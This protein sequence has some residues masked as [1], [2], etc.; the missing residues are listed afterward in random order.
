MIIDEK[1]FAIHEK[2]QELI[3]ELMKRNQ[4]IMASVLD[5]IG[6]EHYIEAGDTH[7]FLDLQCIRDRLVSLYHL[8]NAEF[9]FGRAE[10]QMVN[11][12]SSDKDFEWIKPVME[13]RIKFVEE[14][15]LDTL[16]KLFKEARAFKFK[17]YRAREFQGFLC[18]ALET[19]IKG[20]KVNYRL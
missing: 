15:L 14:E 8:I 6:N 10:L 12:V 19:M 11:M 7:D 4:S 13:S 1:F 5:L 18:T 9:L 2:E 3:L 17:D 16:T 20:Y